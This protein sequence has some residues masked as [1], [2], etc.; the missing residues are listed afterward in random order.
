MKQVFVVKNR[1]VDSVTLM[2][3]AQS[4][5]ALPGVHGAESGMGTQANIDLLASLR[6]TVPEGTTKQDLMIAIDA[7]TDAQCEAACA[8]AQAYLSRGRSASAHVYRALSEI[9]LQQDGY[10]L[11]QI[12][13]PGQYAVKEAEQ[14]LCMGLD[15]FLFSD[16]VSLEDE[17]RLKRLG[18]EKGLLV[19]GPDAG[20][21]LIGGVALAAGSIVQEGPVGIVAASG[22]GAQE[23]AC[24]LERMGVG[25]RCIL[26]TGGRDLQPEIGGI[27][28]RMALEKLRDDAKTAVICLISKAADSGVMESVLREADCLGKPVVAM[29]LGADQALFEGHRSIGARNLE[30]AAVDC[31]KMLRIDAAQWS[32]PDKVIDAWAAS[33]VAAMNPKRRWVHGLYCGGTFAEE[34]MQ[35]IS[36]SCANSRILTNVHVKPDGATL[37]ESCHSLVDMGTEEFTVDAPHPVFDASIRLKHVR[38]A[39]EDAETAAIVLDFITGPGVAQDPFGPF[40]PVIA[41]H[42]EILFIT[43]ICGAAR[44]PQNIEAARVSLEQAGAVVAKS[45]TEAARRMAALILR[46]DGR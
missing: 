31:V 23:I 35:I 11:V 27:S 17:R 34:A 6:Y 18:Q 24:Q 26:A 28:M 7:D 13:L 14:A 32:A 43:H 2:G 42:P 4:L 5:Q 40:L 1:Y 22:S 19:M 36:H 3:A 25:V 39:A 37:R 10:D 45:S 41:Q 44:D 12:S 38:A 15:V 16:H 8:S 33:S 29:F 21:G 30:E 20:V 9:N 46:L